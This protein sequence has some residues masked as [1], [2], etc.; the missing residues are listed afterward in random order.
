[1]PEQKK[2]T[3]KKKWFYGFLWG[4]QTAFEEKKYFCSNIWNKMSKDE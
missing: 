2:H 4:K 1:M 3:Q